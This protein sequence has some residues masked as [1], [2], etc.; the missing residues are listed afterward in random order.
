MEQLWL[1]M[2]HFHTNLYTTRQRYNDI[3]KLTNTTIYRD[4][5]NLD[6]YSGLSG[7]HCRYIH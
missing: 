7:K 1:K 6:F 2:R 4:Q 5:I 3:V